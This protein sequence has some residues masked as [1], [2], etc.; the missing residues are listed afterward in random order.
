MGSRCP[1]GGYREAQ[2]L[3]IEG[4]AAPWRVP[5]QTLITTPGAYHPAP[6]PGF[7]CNHT[8]GANSPAGQRLGDGDM[9]SAPSSQKPP[10]TLG[11][12][13]LERLSDAEMKHMWHGRVGPQHL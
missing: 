13:H 5:S 4:W 12:P 2:Q 6:P 10:L 11:G 3:C 1:T 9:L 8:V 7:S